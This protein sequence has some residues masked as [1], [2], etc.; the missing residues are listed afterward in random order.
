MAEAGEPEGRR[1][2]HGDFERTAAAVQQLDEAFRLASRGAAL[3]PPQRHAINMILVKLARIA[4]GD[5]NHRDHWDDIAGYA[6][7]V[8][9]GL[10]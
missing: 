8:A 4:S 5:Q 9:K 10:K 1:A 2:T 6:S 3:M 7:L